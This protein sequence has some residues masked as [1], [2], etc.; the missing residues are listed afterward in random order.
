MSDIAMQFNIDPAE[1]AAIQRDNDF[2]N[3]RLNEGKPQSKELGQEEFM[4]I[5]IAQLTHQDPTAPM[6]DKEF[7]GQ[8]AQLQTLDNGVRHP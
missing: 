6:E 7:I 1:R 3:A 8:M 4:K 5:L 2:F